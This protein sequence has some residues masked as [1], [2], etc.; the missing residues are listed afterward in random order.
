MTLPRCDVAVVGGGLTGLLAADRLARS[1]ADVLLIDHRGPPAAATARATGV[2]ALGWIDSPARLAAGLGEP[3]TEHLMRWSAE[4]VASLRRTAAELG[5]SWRPTGSL[6][7]ALDPGDA[8][9]WETSIALMQR[10]GLGGGCRPV[11]DGELAALG[12]GQGLVGGAVVPDD[13]VVDL[14]ALV[15]ALAERF[16]A[17][18]G[19]RLDAQV[20]LEAGSGAPILSMAHGSRLTAELVVAAAGACSA[21]LHPF[22]GSCIYPVRLQGLHTAAGVSSLAAPVLARH[23]FEVACPEADGALSFVGCR[24]ADQPEMGAG[25]TDDAQL[26]ERVTARQD[27]WLRDNLGVDVGE[28]RRWSGIV[29]C[30]CDGLPILGPLPGAPRVIAAVGWSGWG[31]ALAPRAVDSICAAILG[32]DPPPGVETPR[33][34]TA[35]RLI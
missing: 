30:T 13:A 5:V 20:T 19:R 10:W 2:V 4:A 32:E 3:I 7:L 18:G 22:F 26:S 29:A 23:R 17:S 31:L 28:P 24:W 9:A 35:R 27:A 21:T 34:L 1:G 8:A 12:P 11:S 15:A 14:S 16:T 25:E 33:A 6:R